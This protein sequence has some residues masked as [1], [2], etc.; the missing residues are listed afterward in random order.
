MKQFRDTPYYVTE[1]GKVFRNGKER[2]LQIVK[3]YG[4]LAFVK[5]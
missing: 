1:D 4:L 2:K 5:K 3:E